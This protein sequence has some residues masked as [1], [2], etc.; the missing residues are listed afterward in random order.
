MTRRLLALLR[1]IGVNALAAADI[2]SDLGTEKLRLA[3]ALSGTLIGPIA[4]VLF[5]STLFAIVDPGQQQDVVARLA[6]L[7]WMNAVAAVGGIQTVLVTVAALLLATTV[8]AKYMVG[9]SQANFLM[10]SFIRQS[11]RIVQAFLYAPPARVRH[12]DRSRVASLAL[13]ESSQ[14][15][16]TVFSL[17]D[18]A[19]NFVA[20]VCFLAAA[21]IASPGL[22]AVSSVV[23]GLTF[24]ITSRGFARQKQLGAQTVEVNAQLMANLWEI[25]NGYRTIKIEGGERRHLARLVEE[26]R[27]KQAW[28]LFKARGELFI[29]LG[30]EGTLY[31]ALLAIVV[32]AV[33]VMHLPA[34][35][36]LVFLVLMGR[37]QKY[38][39]QL[40]QSWILV[41][42][43]L[44]SLEAMSAV[45]AE[46]QEGAAKPLSTEQ[47]GPQ[48]D[49][50]EL[51]F[52]G[53]TF[54]Y[55]DRPAVIRRLDWTARPGDRILIQG[56]SGQ[57]KSTLLFLACGLLSPDEG[58]VLLNGEV[59]TDQRFYRLRPSF[60][61]VAPTTYLFRGSIRENLCF[62]G[63]YSDADVQAAV[64][65]ARLSTL[66]ARLPGGLDADIGENGAALSLGERQRIVLG[67]I[68][69]KKPLLI[70]LD[71]A[72]ANLDLAT[73]AAVLEDLFRNIAPSATVIMVTHRAPADVD[74]THE[75]DLADAS[76]V[77][78]RRVA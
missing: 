6:S 71:E 7:G 42:Y 12:L 59:V 47:A 58:R 76:L 24:L 22:V 4:E 16:R 17:L 43:A 41:Q 45:I 8:G 74:F 67:R 66:V 27:S 15:G 31:L 19:S 51:Q 55:E 68:F 33:S 29:R 23:A 69:L 3:A 18:S 57:G 70:L 21:V 72:T 77:A 28:R 34:S 37:L 53:V 63:E 44:P 1:R 25:L 35:L 49:A 73:E 11:R 30:T 13:T 10:S 61:Y 75:Y 78:R 40:Q 32:L 62:G 46:C 5:I 2:L 52:E 54:A 26:L 14:F 65:K 50:I 48:P 9:I 20:V 39:A 60:S 64:A 56:P 38:L 36:V